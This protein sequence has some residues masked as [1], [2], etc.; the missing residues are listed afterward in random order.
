[1]SVELLQDGAGRGR[2]LNCFRPFNRPGWRLFDVFLPRKLLVD[3]LDP[4]RNVDGKRKR[5]LPASN[6]VLHPNKGNSARLF[7][8][9]KI[10]ASIYP[11]HCHAFRLSV[12]YERDIRQKERLHFRSQVIG[13][14][15]GS[16][17]R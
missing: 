4:A 6:V 10:H 13:D 9:N 17:S 8:T 2:L 14:Q 16:Q 15:I 1:L 7:V 11:I 12:V 5:I 3:R